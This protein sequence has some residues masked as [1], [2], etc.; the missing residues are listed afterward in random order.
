MRALVFAL[1]FGGCSYTFDDEV[2]LVQLVGQAPSLAPLQHLTRLSTD[3]LL[4]MTGVDGAPWVALFELT[5]TGVVQGNVRAVRLADPV[6]EQRFGGDFLHVGRRVVYLIDPTADPAQPTHV[7]VR[8]PGDNGNARQFDLPGG[9]GVLTPSANDAAFLYA[10][11]GRETIEVVRTDG[12]FQ[13]ELAAPAPMVGIGIWRPTFDREA[14][15]VFTFEA[16]GHVALHST[17]DET[18]V[19]L[20]RWGAPSSSATLEAGVL[21]IDDDHQALVF[22][23]P[24]GL[25]R[26]PWDG[27][28]E[29]LLDADPCLGSPLEGIGSRFDLLDGSAV[30][31]VQEGIRSV[32]LDGSAAPK[33]L[34][35]HEGRR[36]L[37]VHP[38]RIAITLDP[39]ERWFR[40][41]SDGWVDGWRFMERG[42]EPAFRKDGRAIRFIEHAADDDST[43]ELR[44]A[45]LGQSPRSL[46]RN[47]TR[48]D[49][50]ADG[51]VLAEA[52]HAFLGA[53]NRL[54]VIDEA[55]GTARWVA[56]GA[57]G[58]TL[59]PGTMDV[60][61][62]LVTGSPDHD[63]V[64]VPVPAP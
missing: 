55:S 31:I 45:E 60:L 20:G 16:D 33:L 29:Q 40:E 37:A 39:L 58:Y 7:L 48:F 14:D 6:V 15:R 56:D 59:I 8:R 13:R 22:C 52:N 51:R 41:A 42:L 4:F 36:V 17:H 43:G 61:A 35:G 46:A 21:A 50:L 25:V 26:V 64:R 12:A 3:S 27:G 9:P 5:D 2:P 49:E 1:V 24:R 28:P 57:S 32:A 34:Q 23:D 30:Y 44:L 10:S 54:I 63:L 18:D 47:V 62:E 19:Q 38:D 11:E 53:Q